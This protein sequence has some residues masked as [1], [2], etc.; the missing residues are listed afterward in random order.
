[1]E[2]ISTEFECELFEAKANE[3]WVLEVIAR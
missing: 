3:P 1:A 2:I